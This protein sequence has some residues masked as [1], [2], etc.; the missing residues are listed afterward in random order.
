[1]N[2]TL[3][4]DRGAAWGAAVGT[5]VRLPEQSGGRTPGARNERNRYTVCPSDTH[6]SFGSGPG[7]GKLLRAVVS[8]APIR[9]PAC[10]P[11]TALLHERMTRSPCT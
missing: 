3:V 10:T 8:W 7:P 5:E 9:L 2:T 1:M 4:Q 11:N 6:V